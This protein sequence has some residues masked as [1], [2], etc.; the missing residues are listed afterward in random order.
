MNAAADAN[1]AYMYYQGNIKLQTTSSGIA[2]TGGVVATG[3][4]S[5]SNLSGTNTGDQ[6]LASLGAAAAVHNHD[7]DYVNVTGDTMTGG[8]TTTGLTL[9]SQNPALVFIDS[10]GSTYQAQWRFIDNDL[11]YVWGPM[12]RIPVTL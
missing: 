1:A 11:Q 5:A 10:S 7:S 6:T 9:T 8:L 12:T 2:V 4:I 3:N